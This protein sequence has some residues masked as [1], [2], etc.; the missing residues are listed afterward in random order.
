MDTPPLRIHAGPSKSATEGRQ[1]A[2]LLTCYMTGST[3]GKNLGTAGYSYDF[4]A[5]LFHPLL[6]RWGEVIPV[7]D[8]STHLETA[9]SDARARGLNPIHVSF[10]PF[11][12]VYLAKTAPNVVVPAW[13]FPDV[14]DHAFADNFQNDWPAMADQC[15]LVV[16]G[17]PFTVQAL[18]RGGTRSPIRVVPVPTP[19][20]YFQAS[21]WEPTN[22]TTVD[23]TGYLFPL[24]N[25]LA[26]SD[27]TAV[28]PKP[29]AV[30]DLKQA[31]K[32]LERSVRRVIKSVLGRSFYSK[33]AR[34]LQSA[35]NKARQRLLRHESEPSK[36]VLPY[37]SQSPLSL[38]G[39]VYTSIFNP[40]DGRKNWQDLLTGFLLALGDREDATLVV[41]LITR[42][43]ESAERLIR[44][45]RGRDIPHR[46]KLIFVCDFMSDEQMRQLVDAST[47]Y[48]QTTK[49]EGNCLPLMNYLAAGRPGI[50]PSHSAISDYF[51]SKVGFVVDSHPEPAAWPHDPGLRLRTSWGRLVWPS[52]YQQLRA[53]YELATQDAKGYAEMADRCRTRMQNWASYEAVES[54]LDQAFSDLTENRLQTEEPTT[55]FSERQVM[56]KAA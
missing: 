51:D 17:G 18:R 43:A 35:W 16:V 52:L 8:P 20:R 38:S 23:C 41:K 34:P 27:P 3:E 19:D 40:D 33:L 32:S 36:V 6:S 53:S 24:P 29:S 9:V 48:L 11:Q 37:R 7:P 25:Q 10:L 54:R 26:S 45:Y 39:V 44:F 47:F 50:S 56:R 12:D 5:R 14:P 13:E 31:G 42:R 30:Y 28:V 2:I 46:C 21:P 4:V 49:A 22:A 15:D 55:A 1:N